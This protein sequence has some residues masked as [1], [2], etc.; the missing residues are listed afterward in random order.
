MDTSEIT[1]RD[2]YIIAQALFLASQYLVRQPVHLRQ[3]NNA[4]DMLTILRA[5][6]PQ[7]LVRMEF[8]RDLRVARRRGMPMKDG[9]PTSEAEVRRWL[10]EHGGDANIVDLF[11]P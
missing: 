7:A 11:E 10:D 3:E 6:Y 9:E 2:H 1:G 5:K 4:E 8:Q